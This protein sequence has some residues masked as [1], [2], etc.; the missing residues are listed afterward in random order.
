[1]Y[2]TEN[3]IYNNNNRMYNHKTRIA[4]KR[5]TQYC[6]VLIKLLLFFSQLVNT[7]TQS[8]RQVKCTTTTQ[9][10]IYMKIQIII[11]LPYFFVL[12][13]FPSNDVGHPSISDNEAEK[14]NKHKNP[15]HPPQYM[16]YKSPITKEF[17]ILLFLFFSLTS[18]STL[19]KVFKQRQ[20]N[21]F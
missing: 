19:G 6:G 7:L 15:V 3:N 11:H 20:P 18:S 12:V 17:F 21:E 16:L 8:N 10:N 5:M 2:R 4:V 14:Q 13:S 1:M 9:Q